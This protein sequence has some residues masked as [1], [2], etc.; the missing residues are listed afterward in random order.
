MAGNFIEEELKR[1]K[2]QGLYR[3]LRQVEG[4]QGATLMLDGREVLNFSSNNYLGLANHPALRAAAIQAIERYGCGSGAS[5]LISGN[6]TLHEELEAKI[7]ALKGTEAA[8]VFNSGYQANIGILSVL[9]DEGDV[10]LSDALNHASIIDGCRLSRAKSVIYPHSDLARLE[11]ELKKA[12]AKAR[13]LIVT[14]T[15]FSM[16]GGEALLAE[17]VELAERYGAMVMV[18]EA[19]ATGVFGP[20]G[21]GV[22][23][24][25]GLVERVQIQMGTLGKALGGFGAYV[26]GSRKLRELLINRSR[27]FIF[28]TALPPAVMAMAIAAIEILY[29]EPERRLALWHNCRALRD[30]LMRL[31]FSLGESQSQI[32]PLIIGDAQKCMAFSERLLEKGV[33]AQGIRPPTVPPGTSRLRITVMATHTH[34]HI[35]RA[36][37]AFEEVRGEIGL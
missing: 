30:G 1:L 34:E 25:L 5:R 36:L 13:K 9:A 35:H 4:E 37:K 19:H 23:A 20:N 12:P 15:L 8:L 11:D 3:K 24:K 29:K 18:D 28:T 10:I 33:F 27:S 22:V 7:A 6:M 17:I 26:A 2:Q 14:E 16:D 31:G 32:Q 21:A